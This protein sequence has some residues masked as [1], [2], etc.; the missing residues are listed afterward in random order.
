MAG[1]KLVQV[2]NVYYVTSDENARQL[3]KDEMKRAALRKKE[4]ER[5]A[6]ELEQDGGM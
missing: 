1:L 5:A 2:D 3:Q 6:K 4:E